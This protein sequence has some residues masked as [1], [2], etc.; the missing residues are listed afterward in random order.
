MFLN[1]I[2]IIIIII[3]NSSRKCLSLMELLFW[4]E[5][6]VLFAA[7]KCCWES[8]ITKLC[9]S[10]KLCIFI[11]FVHYI[12]PGAKPAIHPSGDYQADGLNFYYPE[13]VRNLLHP[14]PL[15]TASCCSQ[16]VDQLSKTRNK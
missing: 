6:K 13:I 4:R 5:S 15:L 1:E 10:V 11:F 3:I 2:A 9:L 12:F 16:Y 8:Y 7:N 14:L